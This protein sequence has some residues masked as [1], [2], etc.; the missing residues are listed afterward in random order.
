MFRFNRASSARLIDQAFREMVGPDFTDEFWKLFKDN[1][2][3]REDI[4]YIKSTGMNSIRVPFHYKLFTDEDYMGLHAQDGFSTSRQR[5][6]V[7][8]R[9]GTLCDP[10]HARCSGGQTGDNIDDSYG[11]PWLFVSEKKPAKVYRHLENDRG[12]LRR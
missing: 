2:I 1:Y 3:T 8:P 6:G 12:T 4:R 11:Y 5:G 7:V 9:V 10:R